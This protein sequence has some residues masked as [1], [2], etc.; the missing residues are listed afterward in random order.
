MSGSGWQASA[1][2]QRIAWGVAIAAMVLIL[3]ASFQPEWFVAELFSQQEQRSKQ[4]AVAEPAP[5]PE[6]LE[7]ATPHRTAAKRP[8]KSTRH[9]V[10]SP[11]RAAVPVSPA[12]ST[13]ATGYYVQVGA[14]HD[15]DRAQGLADQLRRHGR[16]VVI[17]E[18]SPGLHAVWAGPAESH[19]AAA[20][21]QKSL[22]ATQ[23]AKG[24]IIHQQ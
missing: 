12:P 23:H 16:Q 20:A 7:P 9:T 17:T 11:P 4:T 15:R 18:K 3:I 10:K 24:F 6:R 21:L 2:E 22:A 5:P 14:F 19:A 8:L 1:A 13:I